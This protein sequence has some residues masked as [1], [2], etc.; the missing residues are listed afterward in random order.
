MTPDFILDILILIGAI[1]C[2]EY[3]HGWVAYKCGDQTAKL[4]GRLTLNPLKHIDPIGTVILPIALYSF[5]GMPFGWAKPVPINYGNLKSPKRDLMLVAIA[6]PTI[7]ILLALAFGQLAGWGVL[8]GVQ[9]WLFQIVLVNCFLA[10]F[11]LIP[12]PPLDGSRIVLGLLPRRWALFYS[13]LEPWG[14]I[15]VFVLANFGYLSFVQEI[16]M[17]LTRY[18]WSAQGVPIIKFV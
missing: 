3:A 5:F 7:N 17:Y 18:F 10:T 13:R 9:K 8:S 6:G 11:N 4:A 16:A 1:V 12:I 14:F 15:L 2:H